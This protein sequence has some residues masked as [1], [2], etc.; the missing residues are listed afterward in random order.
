MAIIIMINILLKITFKNGINVF[1]QLF[2]NMSILLK[3]LHKNTA[4][5]TFK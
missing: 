5:K 2:I 3:K 1:I 4:I